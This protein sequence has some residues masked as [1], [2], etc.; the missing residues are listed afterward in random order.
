VWPFGRKPSKSV[1]ERL[2]E[3]E[4]TCAALKTSHKAIGLEWEKVYEKMH[5]ALMKLNARQRALA[6]KPEDDPESTN[7]NHTRVNTPVN[8][9][10]LLR[11]VW[12]R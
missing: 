2:D 3:L 10:E 7:G 11:S 4:S 8:D 5:G 6:E 12:G 1:L 9:A